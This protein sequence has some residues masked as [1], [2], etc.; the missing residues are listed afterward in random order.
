MTAIPGQLRLVWIGVVVLVVDQVTKAWVEAV[1][2]L[3]DRIDLLPVFAWVHVQN[4]GAAFSFLAQASGW[5]RW[6]F[7][8]LALIFSVWL[9][10]EMS[11]LRRGDHWLAVAHALVL[12]GALGNLCDRVLQGTVTDFV[13]VHWFDRHY[14][15]AFNVADSAITIGAVLWIGLALFDRRHASDGGDGGS[16]HSQ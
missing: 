4:S 6:F 13:L 2:P 15:P 3:Y 9:L 11:R 1:M 8:A 12:G 10:W 5:Q 14:F 16:V 7:A